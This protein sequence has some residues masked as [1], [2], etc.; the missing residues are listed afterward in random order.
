MSSGRLD[1]QPQTIAQ[2]RGPVI[3]CQ[4]RLLGFGGEEAARGQMYE[5]MRWRRGQDGLLGCLVLPQNLGR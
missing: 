4:G 2:P 3:W 5:A 1:S